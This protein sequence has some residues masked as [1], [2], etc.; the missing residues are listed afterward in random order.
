M[1]IKRGGAIFVKVSDY[2][3]SHTNYYSLR[4][5]GLGEFVLNISSNMADLAGD[6]IYKG[7]LP[8]GIS[9]QLIT[10]FQNNSVDTV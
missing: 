9:H 1:A 4:T 3:T 10:L 8:N 5:T 2:I 6:D 7:S